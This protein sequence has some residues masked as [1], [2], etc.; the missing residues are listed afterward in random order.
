M[1]IEQI[2]TNCIAE[3]AYYI[4]SDGEAAII[5]PLR[6]TEVYLQLA[7]SRG[8]KIK[9]VLE[10]HFHADFVSGHLDLSLA[11]G[12]PIVF[13]PGA[14]TNY[15]I[16]NAYDNE[17][18]SLGSVKIKVLHTPGH[19]PEHVSFLVFDKKQGAEPFGLFTGDTLFNLD[20]GRPDLLGGGTEKELA[21]QLYYSL[22][23]K[24]LPLCDRIENRISQRRQERL[25]RI[26][27]LHAIRLKR[28]WRMRLAA[29]VAVF[30][31]VSACLDCLLEAVP[32][33]K[34]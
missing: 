27:D 30:V 1:Y 9:F 13:G 7:K 31:G 17:L 5:D 26:E 12:A 21:A 23:E 2:Y 14:K 16:K 18:L 29:R 10:T 25:P 32:L 6:D 15:E 22:F 33:Q 11:T 24:I 8:A 19:T 28:S 3:A 20:V 4:E 34:E